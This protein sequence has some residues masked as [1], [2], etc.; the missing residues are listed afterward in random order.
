MQSAD[1]MRLVREFVER[2]SEAAFETL[3]SRWIGFVYS[4]ALRQVRDPHAA[5]EITQAVFI[6][7]AQKA[8]GLHPDTVVSGWLFKTTRF[9][10]LAQIRARMRRQQGELEAQMQSDFEEPAPN[11]LWAKLSP[12]LDEALAQL[13]DKDRQALL[14]RFFE[15]R[16]LAEVGH[17]LG[18][19]ENTA[20]KRINRALGKLQT[21]FQKRGVVSSASAISVAMSTFSVAAPP[22]AL[23]KAVSAALIAKSTAATST[24][25]IA[26]TKGAL[27]LMAWSKVKIA[28]SICAV[29]VLGGGA[30]I[31]TIGGFQSW[32]VAGMPNISGAWQAE[33]NAPLGPETVKMH[34]LLKFTKGL[35]G[36]TGTGS[37]IE[38]GVKDMQIS[39]IDYT[40]PKLRVEFGKGINMTFDGIVNAATKEI[41]GT[42]RQSGLVLPAVFK[43]TDSPMTVPGPLKPRDYAGRAGADLQGFWRGI[44]N[45]GAGFIR[46][47]FKLAQL[48]DGTFRGEMDNL[49][50]VRGQRLTVI[51]NAP[52]VK[53]IVNTGDGMFKGQLD[54]TK[55]KLV[56]HWI[57]TRAPLP[58]T[59][60][61]YVSPYKA[62]EDKEPAVTERVRSLKIGELRADECT[63]ECW[64]Q[65]QQ[66]KKTANPQLAKAIE[67]ALGTLQNVTLVERTTDK[68]R[69]A[70]LYRMEYENLNAL[71]R[72]VL[73]GAKIAYVHGEQE[74]E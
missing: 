25:T 29:V 59:I 73:D 17:R 53:L 5:E 65:L 11:A 32:R 41:P 58:F 19:S 56:G 51:Y 42:I 69:P 61:R 49:E 35:R 15:N 44:L 62:I 24:S 40:F 71:I 1:D 50:S 13:G 4:A 22:A 74:E 16:N 30:T 31:A 64:Q 21:Y 2:H 72:I 12:Q 68:G 43:Y 8:A 3:V 45:V 57:Q 63:P 18:T 7:L 26:L 46:L 33:V 52:D 20:G 9:V 34:G 67:A 37:L 54:A 10:A 23:A 14:L 39:K 60:E 70:Y 47:N 55:S 36:Y 48:P 28:A 38:Q 66:E 6:L 27:K